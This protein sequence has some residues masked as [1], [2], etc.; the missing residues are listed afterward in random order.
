MHFTLEFDT[1]K[2]VS[3]IDLTADINRK[4]AESG[5]QN[6]VATVCSQHTTTAITINENEARL[7]DDVRLYLN[8]LVPPNDHYLH[9]DIHLRDC[10]QDEPENAHAHIAAMLLGAT[11][12]IP[13]QDGSL[14][15][16]TWQSVMLVELDGP[17][18]RSVAIQL[19][20]QNG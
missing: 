20:T 12:S 18:K 14:R 7:V 13:I 5:I 2:G 8:R 16:G 9:N 4:I 10:P 19:S 15:L 3:L 17:R 1:V 11:E 6:G